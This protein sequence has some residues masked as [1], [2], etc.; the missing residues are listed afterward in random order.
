VL[1]L[2]SASPATLHSLIAG[3]F[4]SRAIFLRLLLRTV[5][6]RALADYLVCVLMPLQDQEYLDPVFPPDS[7]TGK[8]PYQRAAALGRGRRRRL[9]CGSPA[10]RQPSRPN[11]SAQRSR[12]LV[13]RCCQVST[14]A[15]SS[16]FRHSQTR[17]QGRRAERLG[18]GSGGSADLSK[19]VWEVRFLAGGDV[20]CLA[21][22]TNSLAEVVAA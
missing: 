21:L 14:L 3:T 13:M 5:P 16:A 15:R 2:L 18:S 20:R 1:L 19:I 8:P 9:R 6:A 10:Q 7:W 12:I 22:A 17:R 11:R 4:R